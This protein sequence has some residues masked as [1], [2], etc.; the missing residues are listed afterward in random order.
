MHLSV[1]HNGRQTK[2]Q[3]VRL[4]L[5]NRARQLF[6]RLMVSCLLLI[7]S[8][9]ATRYSSARRTP[10]NPVL[11][12]LRRQVGSTV[13]PGALTNQFLNRRGIPFAGDLANSIAQVGA[14]EKLQPSPAGSFAL[15]ELRFLAARKEARHNDALAMELYY[16]CVAAVSRTLFLNVEAG[17][18]GTATQYAAT[19]LYNVASEELLRLARD[20]S[21]L[22]PGRAIR[23]PLS[24]RSIPLTMH[25]SAGGW[26]AEELEELEFV[27]E[28]SVSG[29]QTR[30]VSKGMGARLIGVR[31]RGV[32][33]P[34]VEKYYADGLRFPLTAL[35]RFDNPTAPDGQQGEAQY[36]IYDAYRVSHVNMNGGTVE[37]ARDLTTP[38]AR[39]LSRPDLRFLDTYGLLWPERVESVA[40]LYMIQPYDPNKIPVLMVHGIWSSPLTWMEMFNQLQANPEFREKYQFWFY[41]YPTALPFWAAAAD[42]RQDLAEVQQT[43]DP[44]HQNRNMYEMV[45]VGHSMGGLISRMQAVHS[46]N[47][48]WAAMQNSSLLERNQPQAELERTLI[49][50]ANP[51]VR[52][53]VTIASPFK[54][55][56]LANNLT[57]WS[58]RTLISAPAQFF[59]NITTVFDHRKAGK[60]LGAL[61]SF[62][63]VDSLA[64]TSPILSALDCA[65]LAPGVIHHN[66][67][68]QKHILRLK[69]D[70]VVP[71]A[72]AQRNDVQ[73]Q[74]IVRA[75][76]S[77]VQ[78]HP[79][80]VSEVER[81]LN[82]HLRALGRKAQRGQLMLQKPV[83]PPLRQRIGRVFLP[84]LSL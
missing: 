1:L 24:G 11:E 48:F 40:G 78:R 33:Q 16:D 27:S 45:L 2:W 36:D 80:A 84:K 19:E 58:A 59:G 73:S 56:S 23:L 5:I 29:L 20:N 50:N 68:G 63:S 8:G 57:R 42:L 43:F 12:R 53:I 66:I 21:I 28:Y 64:P 47:A 44:Q 69:S 54:G 71:V 15:A 6:W 67:I 9:C 22:K 62:T 77:N 37:L 61:F 39:F 38:L 3:P 10:E 13:K 65:P 55:S 7:F 79:R 46:G 60:S 76:H 4:L 82:D 75:R 74:I 34:Q 41:L 51:L 81:I 32:K 30:D 72:S 83:D 17:C 52:R 26:Q 18:C 35:I 70:Y 14:A 25:Q 49:F 31:K